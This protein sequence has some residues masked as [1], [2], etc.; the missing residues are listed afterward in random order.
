MN[1]GMPLPNIFLFSLWNGIIQKQQINKELKI[2]LAIDG[3][4]YEYNDDDLKYLSILNES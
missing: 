2:M 1:K 3:S 4:S